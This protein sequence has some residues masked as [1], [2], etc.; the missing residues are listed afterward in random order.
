MPPDTPKQPPF[1]VAP[2][3]LSAW[4]EQLVSAITHGA[5]DS[6]APA[7]R[8]RAH[9]RNLTG[10]RRRA[11]EQT[12]P[13]AREKQ[14]GAFET[15][16]GAWL[17]AGLSRCADLEHESG[18]LLRAWRAGHIVAIEPWDTRNLW[19][20]L[21]AVEQLR[22][23][24]AIGE[25]SEAPY[26]LINAQ[27]IAPT[28]AVQ[29]LPHGLDAVLGSPGAEDS[30]GYLVV[31]RSPSE[32]RPAVTAIDADLYMQLIALSRSRSER[33]RLPKAARRQLVRLGWIQGRND[34][35]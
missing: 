27:R 23:L 10:I 20:A 18:A 25:V 15:M 31:A 3:E 30:P 2:A 19:H 7:P 8:L 22:Q 4:Q 28:A 29:S 9:S 14:P 17:R 6:L 5:D 32:Q 21:L 12:F 13:L 11:L 1:A 26:K 35:I 33:Q 34:A 24:I 16:V